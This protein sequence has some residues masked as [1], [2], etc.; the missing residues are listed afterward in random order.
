MIRALARQLGRSSLEPAIGHPVV[1][2]LESTTIA[3]EINQQSG[4][5]EVGRRG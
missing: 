4:M 2:L 5:A 1:V 3:I